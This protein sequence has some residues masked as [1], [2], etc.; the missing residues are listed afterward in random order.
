[1][2]HDVFRRRPEESGY[3]VPGSSQYKVEAERFRA[4][5][6]AITELTAHDP[7]V[8]TGVNAQATVPAANGGRA[9][10]P[11]ALTF[12]DGGSS[13]YSIIAPMLEE[14]GWRGHFFVATEHLGS[15]GFITAA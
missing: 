3:L 4:H 13:A 7:L 5:L 2:Y 14:Y 1:M 10:L 11:F 6:T 9:T 8:A 12:D 15:D